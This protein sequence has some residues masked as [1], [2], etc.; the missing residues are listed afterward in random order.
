MGIDIDA[1]IEGKATLYEADNLTF[2]QYCARYA[3]AMN[4][5]DRKH[6]LDECKQN[7]ADVDI[8]KRFCNLGERHGGG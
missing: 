2:E 5:P 3:P 4:L 1:R 8:E 7:S 6:R